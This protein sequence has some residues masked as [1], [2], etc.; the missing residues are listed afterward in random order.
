MSAFGSGVLFA[1]GLSVAGMTQPSK[2]IGFLDFFGSWDPTLAFVMLGAIG[3]HFGLLRRIVR[4]R[5]PLF[6]VK[7]RLPNRNEV[8]ARL[9]VGSALFGVGWGLGGICPGPAIV[10]LGT[11]ALPFV[12]FFV[13]M[14]AGMIVFR[15]FDD[16]MKRRRSESKSP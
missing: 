10:A 4:R 7:F 1:L 6:E 13:A 11:G 8:D 15:G 14:V 3:V 12:A 16:S 5:A 2:V 9:L